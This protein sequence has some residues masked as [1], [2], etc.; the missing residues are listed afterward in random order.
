MM[1][2]K[3]NAFALLEVFI[4][5]LII[6]ILI[7]SATI[8]GM[9]INDYQ[10]RKTTHNKM[11]HI[12][13]ALNDFVVANGRLP[14]PVNPTVNNLTQS[15]TESLQTGECLSTSVIS[16]A[17][18]NYF[19]GAV[20]VDT[21]KIAR[22]YAQDD[23]G[24]KIMYIVPKELTFSGNL[25][26]NAVVVYN[27]TSSGLQIA[28][29]VIYLGNL[30]YTANTNFSNYLIT[31]YKDN[32]VTAQLGNNNIYVLLSYGE[33]GLGAYTISGTRNSTT[34]SDA[35]V[36]ED[37]NFVSG[38]VD[39]IFYT[40]TTNNIKGGKLDDIIYTASVN[41]IA[42]LN[43]SVV[44]CDY[45]YNPY[46]Q[47]ENYTFTGTVTANATSSPN[48]NGNPYYPN[49]SMIQ[50]TQNCAACPA[51]SGRRLYIECHNG[52]WGDVIK[53]DCTC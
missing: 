49:S 37:Q 47:A 11:Q 38:K 50:F 6:T 41:D 36:G 8:P 30:T 1:F 42:S 27:N 21:L 13:N 45:Q 48:F 35:T 5:M 20:P 17:S 23:W 22:E 40:N 46:Y 39:N 53:R 18:G 15:Y 4:A 31:Q 43:S 28:K 26:K 19:A 7:S 25:N 3:N 9:I 44:H 34:G 10:K 51:V 29:T 2:K 24:N 52:N 14:C 16:F 32:T 12:Q 33:N